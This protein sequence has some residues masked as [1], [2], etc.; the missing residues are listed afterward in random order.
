MST[1][2]TPE[3]SIPNQELETQRLQ[4]LAQRIMDHIWNDVTNMLGQAQGTRF[5][6]LC[7]Q[8]NG[9]DSFISEYPLPGNASVALLLDDKSRTINI[10]NANNSNFVITHWTNPLPASCIFELNYNLGPQ[11]DDRVRTHTLRIG[12]PKP[13]NETTA[14]HTASLELSQRKPEHNIAPYISRD[15]LGIDYQ[16]ISPEGDT[17]ISGIMVGGNIYPP[18]T[19]SF[20]HNDIT[21]QIYDS[22]NDTIAIQFEQGTVPIYRQINIF[23]AAMSI[24]T[25][26]T[27]DPIQLRQIS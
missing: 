2:L 1:S 27:Y 11:M 5:E 10:I 26:Q 6:D 13:G 20:T 22:I 21:Y 15:E 3:A 16:G 17:S 14:R 24:W 23:D 12:H 18:D 19:I 4:Q 7:T 8:S 25:P 9:N